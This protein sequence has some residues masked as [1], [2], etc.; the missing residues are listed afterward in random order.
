VSLELIYAVLGYL[1]YLMNVHGWRRAR[2]GTRAWA[3]RYG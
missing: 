1:G 3:R 2:K